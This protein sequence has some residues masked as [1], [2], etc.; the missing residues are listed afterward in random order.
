MNKWIFKG[1]FIVTSEMVDKGALIKEKIPDEVTGRFDCS[2][3]KLTSLEG[4]PSTVGGGFYCDNNK[5]NLSIEQD[6][7]KSGSC[8]SQE[9]F[10]IDLC[11]YM[12]KK[13]ID[14]NKITTWPKGFLSPELIASALGIAKFML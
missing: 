8:S 2:S 3:N 6:F 12:I 1:D 7:I 10:F 13:K 11:R 14:L 9:N 5:L 4:C